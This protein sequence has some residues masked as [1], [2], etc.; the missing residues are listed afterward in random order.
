MLDFKAEVQAL[1]K[2][3]VALGTDPPLAIA[4]L[5]S[6]GSGKS[7][8]MLQVRDEVLRLAD[9]ARSNPR[10]SAFAASIRQI[11][12]GTTA[13]PASGRA[14]SITCSE[15]LATDEQT[16]RA[17]TADELAADRERLSHL[18]SS[19]ERECD[20]TRAALEDLAPL[21]SGTAAP[22]LEIA[23]RFAERFWRTQAASAIPA[24]I[25]AIAARLVW[26]RYDVLF[27]AL[28]AAVA[29]F[30]APM[31]PVLQTLRSTGGR[32]VQSIEDQRRDLKL[33]A[34][35]SDI[36]SHKSRLAQVDAAGR[37][38]QAFLSDMTATDH[39][40]PF[41]GIVGQVSEDL[42]TLNDRLEEAGWSGR[43]PDPT[44]RRPCSASSSTSM[45]STGAHL[46]RCW[47]LSRPS[48]SLS[49]CRSSWWSLASILP[50]CCS[51]W[52][53]TTRSCFR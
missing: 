8:F 39:Y 18:L 15:T 46:T 21:S 53:S 17:A 36:A 5:G 37:L 48:T 47:R 35:Q 51:R 22:F 42:R 20:V 1:A 49:R 33:E 38:Q 29:A 4:L 11:M 27:G 52:R 2:L 30:F 7:S 25:A 40:Q 12:C 19:A 31:L 34:L 24:I 45:I 41:T 6:W 23:F 9:T 28:I 44:A 13:T 26:Q 32:V 3:V 43:S 10:A 14:S 50:G 16:D